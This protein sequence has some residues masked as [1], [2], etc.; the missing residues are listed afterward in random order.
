MPRPSPPKFVGEKAEC[1]FLW[2]AMERDFFVAKP[3]GDSAPYDFIVQRRPRGPLLR[4]QVKTANTV[5]RSFYYASADCHLGAHGM[6][7]YGRSEIDFFAIWVA[8]LQVWYLIPRKAV[9]NAGAIGVAPHRPHSRGKY[10]KYREAWRL[11]G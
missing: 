7:R 5:H 9:A 2:H 3:Y 4:V 1:A 8:P 11:L 6:R 10:E